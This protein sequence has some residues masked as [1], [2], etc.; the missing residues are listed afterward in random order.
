MLICHCPPYG[1]PL[2]Q[3]RP[4]AHAGSTAVRDFLLREQPEHFFCGHIHEAAGA[5]VMIGK[6]QAMNVGKQGWLLNLD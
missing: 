3:I 6:T 5:R 1:T 4:G 2:D